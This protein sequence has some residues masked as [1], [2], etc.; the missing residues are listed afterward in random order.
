MD[1]VSPAKAPLP[2][3][4]NAPTDNVP[5]GDPSRS[6]DYLSLVDSLSYL[7]VGTRPDL[8]YAVNYM[9]RFSSNPSPGNWK[10]LKHIVHYIAATRKRRLHIHPVDC[11]QPLRC[12][13]DAVWRGEFQRS[14][15]G[16]FISFFGAPI[17]W[18]ARRLH[19]IAASTCQAEYMAL[20]MA[21]RH[22]LWVQKLI[23]DFMGQ[24]F[25]GHLLCD[26]ES[27]I[28]V[29]KDDSSNKRTRHTK[30]EYYLTN[31]ALFEGKATLSWIASDKQTADILTKALTPEKH[32]TLSKAIQGEISQ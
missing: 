24:S 11:E 8:A 31:Q 20:G 21:T 25:Q 2:S 7:A 22:L 12:Y 27:A 19:T 29:S 18:I 16:I 10:A 17:L 4:Y 26:N 6:T 30:R 5:D 14:A 1:K 28:K 32:A 9:A 15:Y 23:E 13:S 3:S